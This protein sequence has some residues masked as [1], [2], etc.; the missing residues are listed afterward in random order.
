MS[1]IFSIGGY[2]GHS[3]EFTRFNPE[4]GLTLTD[5]FASSASIASSSVVRN[6]DVVF[7]CNITFPTLFN[8]NGIIFEMGATAVGSGVGLVDSGNTLRFVSGD[9]Q[10]IQD[11]TNGVTLDIPTS[12]FVP[13]SSGILVWEYTINPGRLRAWWSGA[14]LGESFTSENGPL[15]SSLWAGSDSGA[16]LLSSSSNPPGQLINGNW[17]GTSQSNLRY[18]SNQLVT[19]AYSVSGMWSLDAAR[20]ALQ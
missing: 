19:S 18:Y 14:F 9:G 7:A 2:I 10:A 13:G 1:K 17:P 11:S 3:P 4:F 5:S 20:L 12:S 8:S 16:Y 6:L 15:R